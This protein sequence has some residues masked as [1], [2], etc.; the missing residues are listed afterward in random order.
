MR[1]CLLLNEDLVEVR[2]GEIW[3]DGRTPVLEVLQP[4]SRNDAIHVRVHGAFEVDPLKGDS[5]RE[6]AAEGSL[7]N[8]AAQVSADLGED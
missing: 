5:G 6:G 2:R 7:L 4:P 3:L 1:W 8:L